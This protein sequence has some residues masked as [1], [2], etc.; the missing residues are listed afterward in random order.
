MKT[1]VELEKE[2]EG[3]KQALKTVNLINANWIKVGFANK[4]YNLVFTNDC[5][6]C[7]FCDSIEGCYEIPMYSVYQTKT[8]VIKKI[9]KDLYLAKF[10]IDF[11]NK[12]EAA[13]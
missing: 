8:D 1:K 6:N 10:G 3:L 13:K 12:L 2:I 9:K 11:Q 5:K 4:W 7:N